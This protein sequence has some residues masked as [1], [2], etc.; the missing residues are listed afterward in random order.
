MVGALGI[1]C[2][3]DARLTAQRV[4]LQARVVGK[5]AHVVVV[6]D[7][8]GLLQC[9]LLE[10]VVILGNVLVAANVVERQYFK[11][12]AENLADFVELMLIVGGENDSFH[13][14]LFA[15][16]LMASKPSP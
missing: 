6:N 1:A 15:L 10:R 9:I 16:T 2:T 7:V 13:F 12:T 5:A 8:L 11:L 3:V 14:S 4:D